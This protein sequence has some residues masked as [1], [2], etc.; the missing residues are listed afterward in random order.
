MLCLVPSS[1]WKRVPGSVCGLTEAVGPAIKV[2]WGLSTVSHSDQQQSSVWDYHTCGSGINPCRDMGT[3]GKRAPRLSAEREEGCTDW[4]SQNFAPI[5][6][7]SHVIQQDEAWITKTMM[8][9]YHYC[10]MRN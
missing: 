7:R 2:Y 4:V 8:A 10:R 5:S 9:K 3:R 1:L 6:P